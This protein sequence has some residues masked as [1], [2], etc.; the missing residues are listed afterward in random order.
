MMFELEKSCLLDLEKFPGAM[1][2]C[3]ELGTFFLFTE[4]D[5]Y[6]L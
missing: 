5:P 3:F 4:D 6:L 1:F 2:D